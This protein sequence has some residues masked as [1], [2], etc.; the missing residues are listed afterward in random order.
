MALVSALAIGG[1][2]VLWRQSESEKAN[3]RFVQGRVQGR[4]EK[5]D[6]KALLLP[7]SKSRQIVQ[8]VIEW[9]SHYRSAVEGTPPAE[10]EEKLSKPLPESKSDTFEI[11]SGESDQSE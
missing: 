10:A 1:G 2:Y 8:G 11:G 6:G 5:K 7:G 3:Q 9:D 4:A